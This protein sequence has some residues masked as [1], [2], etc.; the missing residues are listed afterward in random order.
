MDGKRVSNM[1]MNNRDSAH[2]KK[3]NCETIGNLRMNCKKSQVS[4]NLGKY[5]RNNT[6]N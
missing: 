4:L 6:Y 5:T 2:F 3:R 1:Q